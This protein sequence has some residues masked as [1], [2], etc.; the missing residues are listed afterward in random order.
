M[1]ARTA[2][3]AA[4]VRAR[5]LDVQ[6]LRAIASLLVASYHIWFGTVSG[7][8]D[9]F[10]VLGGYL[11]VTSIVGEVER[12]GRFSIAAS[13]RGQ[14]TRLLPMMGV[15]LAAS[16]AVAFT[17]RPS[18]LARDI[19]LDVLAASTFWENWRLY[20][21]ATDYVESGL[22]RSI[23]QHFWA[24]GVQ[25]QWTLGAIVVAG[26]VAAL[27]GARARVRIRRAMLAVLVVVGVASFGVALAG[28]AADPVRV[29]YDT[30]AR[31]WELALG[32][33][34]ALVGA[35]LAI[36]ALA[37]GV[38]AAAGLI[39]VVF[40]GVLLVDEPHPGPATLV[41]T[42][43]AVA[44]LVAGAS[45]PTGP[46][47]AV[48]TSR[49]LVAIGDASFGLFLW[50]WP[51]LW[52]AIE[53]GGDPARRVG[54]LEGLGIIAVAFA[55]SVATTKA[56]RWVAR[57]RP[58][59][60]PW[61][62]ALVPGVA[63]V[64][65]VAAMLPPPTAAPIAEAGD[66]GGPATSETE[67]QDRIRASATQ[68]EPLQPGFHFGDAARNPEWIVDGCGSVGPDDF[69]RCVYGDGDAE[70]WLVGDSHAA[71]WAPA[72]RFAVADDVRVRLVGAE[73]CPFSSSDVLVEQLGEV[74]AEGCWRH[75]EWVLTAAEERVPDLVVVS[76]GAW[77]SG[78]SF[79]H[80]GSDAVERLAA[81]T[82]EQV[83]RLAAA[84]IPVLLL[85][86]PPTV[87]AVAA[88]ESALAGSGDPQEACV[89][90]LTDQQLA[91][92]AVVA[93]AVV[94][95]GGI[96][97]PTLDWFCDVEARA[98]PLA[99]EGIPVWS[100]DVHM[101]WAHANVMQRVVQQ[102]LAEVAPQLVDSDDSETG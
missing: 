61:T 100:D 45:G 40:S 26:V 62:A 98:C 5:R 51:I 72:M 88:C 11:L 55:L 96:V 99:A 77:W 46:A 79:E 41:P 48:L 27:L 80:L 53:L 32:G 36:P 42:L 2:T 59:R 71:T 20:D 97:H 15:V 39:A 14:A 25:G 81:S 22:E 102:A 76:Y 56:L 101:S 85:D 43:G 63:V 94:D 54:A 60:I 90:D 73:A 18:I 10:F 38:L 35:R 19:G 65:F 49:P 93:Q 13:L 17:V 4:P 12:T 24:M 92:S 23:V 86:S 95:G 84:G 50:H 82:A 31:A 78:P 33:I 91:R 47:K 34:A 70:V 16:A 21:A 87:D 44:V 74:A 89:S 75:N 30:G 28:V 37:R 64:G 29:Y 6:G 9:V 58:A 66:A 83:A 69:D 7:G 68:I 67:L 3:D 1:A 8:V 52:L 57:R